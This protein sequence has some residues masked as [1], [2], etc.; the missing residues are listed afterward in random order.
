MT[1]PLARPGR[2]GHFDADADQVGRG[3]AGL[4]VAVLD[5]LRQVLERQALRRVDAGD[6]DPDEI[7]RL[8]QALIALEDAFADMREAL[9]VTGGEITLPIDVDDLVTEVDRAGD[10]V[11]AHRT[12]R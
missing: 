7:E 12:G 11:D 10:A 4:V 5:V 8:G 2:P 9:G 1:G 3:L 6:L